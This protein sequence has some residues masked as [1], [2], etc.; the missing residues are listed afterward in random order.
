MTPPVLAFLPM[1]RRL[2]FSAVI[3]C[4]GSAGA[5]L[6]QEER[7]T[8]SNEAKPWAL[9]LG[10]GLVRS[11]DE[12]NLYFSAS[13]RRRIHF[14]PRD[15]APGTAAQLPDPDPEPDQGRHGRV[16]VAPEVG[17]W[18][19]TTAGGESTK[20]ILAGVSLVGVVP[21]RAF[22]L[23]I[24]AGFDA[25]FLDFDV[26]QRGVLVHS[27]ATRFG[28]NLQFGVE[29]D[30]AKNVGIFGEGRVDILDKRPSQQS[31]VSAGLRFRF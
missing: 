16:Y 9:G 7:S 13:L 26:L 21:T 22:D 14:R 25:H 20:D 3:L 10:V 2:A 27:S 4:L 11:N 5:A 31:K 8:P 19:S 24:G 1:I 29:A 28:G 6:A 18:K 30:L 17:Y 23:F 15:E 12:G